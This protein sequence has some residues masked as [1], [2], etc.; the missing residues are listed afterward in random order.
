MIE[1]RKNRKGRGV[2]ALKNFKPGDIIERSP[3][4]TVPVKEIREGDKLSY[5][6]F[7]WDAKFMA[8][9]LGIGS[10]FNHSSK[11]NAIY[12]FKERSQVI[13]FRAYRPIKKGEEIFIN[14][15]F[16]P[17]DETPIDFYNLRKKG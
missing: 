11:A 15:N 12:A 16:D 1:V 10:L 13:E 3:I 14:Y 17:D 4:I 5:Y 9:A 7:C 2:Y 6:V 8:L